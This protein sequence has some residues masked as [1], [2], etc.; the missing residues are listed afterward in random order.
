MRA[1]HKAGAAAV[2]VATPV[3]SREAH[4]L[5]NREADQLVI[6]QTPRFLMAI[7]EWYVN[8]DQVE[9][10]EVR[11][12]LSVSRKDASVAPGHRATP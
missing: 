3:A 5:V 8:F 10:E 1:A 11:R 9:D 12:L 6:L 2:I 7:G 4:A